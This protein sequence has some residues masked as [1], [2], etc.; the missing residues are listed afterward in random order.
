MTTPFTWTP[1]VKT[2]GKK[3]VK[4]KRALIRKHGKRRAN[5]KPYVHHKDKF[6]RVHRTLEDAEYAR[7]RRN[8]PLVVQ[9]RY[10]HLTHLP[11]LVMFS[12]MGPKP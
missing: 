12:P 1:K 3:S 10:P 11:V 9:P 2:M 7:S 6:V 5:S 8:A 4:L